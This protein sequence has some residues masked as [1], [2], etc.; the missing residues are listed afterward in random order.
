[1]FNREVDKRTGYTT[2]SILCMPMKDASDKIIGVFQ[3]LNKQSGAFTAED[4]QLLQAFAAQAGIAVRNA[5]LNEEIRK[6]MEVSETLLKVMKSVASELRND[7]GEVM[8]VMQ[9]LNKLSG[10]FTEEDERLLNA[11]GSQI[12]ISIENSRL[13][14]RVVF[15]QNYNSS[16]LGSIATGV[17]TLGPDGRV[18][19]INGA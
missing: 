17:V 11:L 5:M 14:E 12:S 1:R 7:A 18:I 4:E 19:F 8:G 10:T 16:I 13:F 6:R 3:L 15:M 9:V 2:R